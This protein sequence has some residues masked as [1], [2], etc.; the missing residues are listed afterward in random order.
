M[1]SKDMCSLEDLALLTQRCLGRAA[2]DCETQLVQQSRLIRKLGDAVC[3]PGGSKKPPL[4][5]VWRGILADDCFELPSLLASPAL[6]DER[7]SGAC[8]GLNHSVLWICKRRCDQW[9]VVPGRW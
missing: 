6:V 2:E 8:S 1:A 9:R 4:Q 5:V 7:P 3:D